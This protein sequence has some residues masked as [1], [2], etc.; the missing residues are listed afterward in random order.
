MKRLILLLV[1][2]AATMVVASGVAVAVTKIGGPSPDHLRGTNGD[3][4][5]I[6]RGGNDTLLSLAGYDDLLG[7]R[8]NDWVLGTNEQRALGGNKNLVG[9]PGN[10]G[11]SA[12]RTPITC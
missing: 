8:G 9:G 5:L 3:D 7:G 2:M 11:F 1:T 4:I 6:G 12:A 10:D